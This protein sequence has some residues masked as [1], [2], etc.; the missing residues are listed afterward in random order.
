MFLLPLSHRVKCISDLASLES[1]VFQSLSK[2]G[3]DAYFI[4]YQNALLEEAS[5]FN[6][7]YT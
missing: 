1:T 6:T 4:T 2:I 5:S 7:I 3:D